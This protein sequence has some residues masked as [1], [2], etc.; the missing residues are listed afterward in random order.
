MK[1][2]Q[3]L[4]D[5]IEKLY[6]A[7]SAFPSTAKVGKE[8]LFYAMEEAQFDWREL[9]KSVLNEYAVLCMQKNEERFKFNF[10]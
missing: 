7:D 2:K 10:D 9:P 3:E 1:T 4:I 5:V 6:P 8:L